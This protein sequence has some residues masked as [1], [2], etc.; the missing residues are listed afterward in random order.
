MKRSLSLI[1]RKFRLLFEMNQKLI[2]E[3]LTT[4]RT[5]R[6]KHLARCL[7]IRQRIN[8]IPAWNSLPL[9]F[10]STVVVAQERRSNLAD[11]HLRDSPESISEVQD[12]ERVR[13]GQ[14]FL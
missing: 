12:E 4:A 6:D 1:K 5:Y 9:G 8:C 10:T 3:R 7:S 13:H 11:K 2:P 14:T